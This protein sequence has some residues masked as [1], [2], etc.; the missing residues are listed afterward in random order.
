MTFDI[1]KSLDRIDKM[2]T[3]S[4]DYHILQSLHSIDKM[5]DDRAVYIPCVIIY[6]QV[7][8]TMEKSESIK[9]EAVVKK[10]RCLI[11]EIFSILEG[12]DNCYGYQFVGNS[13]IA[14]MRCVEKSDM[15]K[16]F[17]IAAKV[18]SIV[19]IINFKLN[20][21]NIVS[22]RIG[23]AIDKGWML[24]MTQSFVNSERSG[25]L[26][27]GYMVE[28]V[29]Q[30]ASYAGSSLYDQTI[31]ISKAVYDD[32]NDNY[33]KLFSYNNTRNCYNSSAVNIYMNNWLKKQK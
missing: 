17:E 6:I 23:I 27:D 15:D 16:A 24:R 14:F 30:M 28:R 21:Y 26:W 25:M 8:P 32:L 12:S 29:R 5:E 4:D 18:K 9:D 7:R 10:H 2:L 33:Q 31:M 22:T 20:K 19:D 11:S 13:F 3:A 1:E